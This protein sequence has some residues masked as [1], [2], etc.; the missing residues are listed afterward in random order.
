MHRPPLINAYLISCFL[1]LQSVHIVPLLSCCKGTF[2]L[3]IDTV[4][5]C[6]P[7]CIMC[8]HFPSGSS[9]AVLWQMKKY[10]IRSQWFC[11]QQAC[12][13][14]NAAYCNFGEK[15]RTTHFSPFLFGGTQ[16]AFESP[17]ANKRLSVWF[18]ICCERFKRRCHWL[19]LCGAVL[20]NSPFTNCTC[21]TWHLLSS[22]LWASQ[23]KTEGRNTA[24]LEQSLHPQLPRCLSWRKRQR[25]LFIQ[26]LKREKTLGCLSLPLSLW[27]SQTPIVI[28]LNCCRLFSG[29]DSE[30]KQE[31]TQ[32][33]Q[34]HGILSQSNYSVC[35]CFFRLMCE[36]EG[37]SADVYLC[38][39][40]GISA[41]KG[42][43]A[44]VHVFWCP[45]KVNNRIS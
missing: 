21:S 29:S 22:Q 11:N 31:E 32:W 28:M 41:D 35:W 13:K 33:E 16:I 39:W 2:P 5:V 38:V 26:R 42:V 4:S 36:C 20:K 37:I 8:N 15:R 23:E 34:Q 18:E 10:D 17:L 43:C 19:E 30:L 6:L 40:G 9:Q 25:S 45:D 1:Q 7:V 27:G 24:L 3:E 44:S 14:T 12:L